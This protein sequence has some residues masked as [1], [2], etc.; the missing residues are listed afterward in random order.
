MKINNFVFTTNYY[1]TVS[2]VYRTLDLLVA[3]LAGIAPDRIEVKS[4]TS[5]A[6]GAAPYELSGQKSKERVFSV[7][8]YRAEH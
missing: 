4:S 6:H 8:Q 2:F 5:A 1:D 7:A 3:A